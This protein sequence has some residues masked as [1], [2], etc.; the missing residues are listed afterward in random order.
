MPD[1][2]THAL[3]LYVV[4]TVASWRIEWLTPS[5]VTVGM[6]GAMIPDLTKIKLVVPSHRVESVLG[7]PFDWFALHTLGGSL[8][9]VLI[10]AVLVPSRYRTRVFSLLALGAT[11]HL[12]LDAL[13]INPSGYSY[14]LFWPLT[15][16]HPPTPGLYLSTDRWPALAAG[17][18]AAL[19]RLHTRRL[20]AD[21][22][23]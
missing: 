19:V 17:A 21:R 14:A 22:G 15:G 4:L 20:R 18:L 3:V 12:L 7:V 9:S 10:G 23:P 11:S 13:L 16:Y 2:L 5:F 8:V 6:M 1:L